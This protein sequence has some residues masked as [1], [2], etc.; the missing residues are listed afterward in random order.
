MP[1]LLLRI[2]LA[3]G[4]TYAAIASLVNPQAWVGFF[5][6]WL[7]SL[8]AE[9][10]LLYG[11]S[12]FEIALSLWLLSGKKVFYA[13]LVSAASLLAITVFNFAL[14]DIVFR[15]VSLFFAALAL[16]MLARR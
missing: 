5:P 7:R 1:S 15:D 14:M 10:I 6:F 13:A 3:F 12:F 16:A 4:F 9:P 8:V 2:G 11:F